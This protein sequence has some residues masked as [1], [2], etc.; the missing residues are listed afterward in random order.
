MARR[1]KKT[2][3]AKSIEQTPEKSASKRV[4]TGEHT[5]ETKK[6]VKKEKKE[7]KSEPAV[8]VDSFPIFDGKVMH[9][10]LGRL[11]VANRVIIC[12]NSWTAWKLARYFDNP[13]ACSH[14]KSPRHFECYTGLFQG[15]PI[16]VIGSGMGT[17]MMDFAI[18]E[19]RFLIDGPMAVVRFGSAISVNKNVDIGNVVLSSKGSFHVQ[20]DYDKL[21]D[22]ENKDLPY[23]ISEVTKPDQQ[24]SKHLELHLQNS[25]D[26]TDIHDIKAE[27]RKFK[28]G[29]N[30][31]TDSFYNSQCRLGTKFDDQNENLFEAIKEM[32]GDVYTLEMENYSIYALANMAKNSDVYAASCSI[33]QVSKY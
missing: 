27:D 12:E 29:L 9:L 17:P 26:E 22:P 19:S 18:R 33:V 28:I 5:E 30:G 11:D 16:S 20:T 2:R 15:V 25:I 8:Q 21:H 23:K 31:T 6:V 3:S 14:I 10:S 7:K 1:H 24:L 32:H 4:K 13:N